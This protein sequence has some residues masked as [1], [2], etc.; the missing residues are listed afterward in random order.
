MRGKHLSQA[1]RILATGREKQIKVA[2]EALPAEGVRALRVAPAAATGRGQLHNSQ[3][4]TGLDDWL[5][6]RYFFSEHGPHTTKPHLRQWWRRLTGVNLT[7]RQRMHTV[8]SESGTQTAAWSPDGALPLLL[9]RSPT[10]L[11][12]WLIHSDFSVAVAAYTANDLVG[13]LSSQPLRRSPSSGTV[14]MVTLSRGMMCCLL[15]FFFCS[16]MLPYTRMSLNRKNCRALGFLRHSLVRT[17]SPI[18]T[19]PG[20]ASGWPA[21]PKQPSTT[22]IRL[23]LA[24]LLASRS[25]IFSAHLKAGESH[26]ASL[27][28]YWDVFTGD[29]RGSKK[30]Q[31]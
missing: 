3:T 30:R 9:S 22:P 4:R 26:M 11:A 25:T 18:S 12:M 24:S 7:L 1:S 21:A 17:P 27:A 29:I 23:E 10:H 8:A 16:T 20:M 6:S 19:R 13:V 5:G 2:V 14:S 15:Y 31:H 28:D